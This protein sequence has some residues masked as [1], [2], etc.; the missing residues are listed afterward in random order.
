MKT[1]Q[2]FVNAQE[3]G[4]ELEFIRSAIGEYRESE[5]YRI[6]LDADEYEA[7]RNI[8][9]MEFMRLMFDQTGQKVVDF[10]SANNRIASNYFHRLVTQRVAYSL[11]N[12]IS[13][14][15]SQRV[16]TDGKWISVDATKEKLGD[17][18]DTV[19]YDAGMYAREH[20][21]SYLFWNL[22]HADCFKATEFC[23]LFDEYDGSLKAGIRFWSLDWENRP[24]TVVVYEADGYTKYRT[25]EKSKGLDLVL[26]EPK[27][28]YKQKIAHNGV[29]PDEVVGE[30]NYNYIPIVPFWGSKHRQSDLV[31]MR[32]KIDALD[33]VSSGFCNDLQDCAEVYWIIS[34]AIGMTDE[35]LARFREKMKLQHIV[36]ADTDN[37]PVTPYKQEIPTEARTALIGFLRSQIYEDYGGLDVHTIAAGATNDHIDAAYQPM[38]EEAD[39]FEYQCIKAIRG[40]LSIIGID[41]MPI[42]HRN[43]VSNH[44]QQTQMVMMTAN[45]LDDE[46]VIRKLPFITPD[47]AESVIARRVAEEQSLISPEG[48]EEE[49]PEV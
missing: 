33:L 27:R 22:D 28:A 26:Y 31:G 30:S 44:M 2:D 24:V 43:K 8:T 37:S 1:Y 14:A 48:E 35:D 10:T 11:G 41:D 9:I 25:R 47:E 36:V 34:N 16:F 45:Y 3:K 19:L 29:D 20:R 39:D 32:S 13:F 21:V 12:G 38:D 6:A 5:E 49:A 4:Q 42:F 18:F 17:D 15:N 23:P 7:E 40:I 46:T